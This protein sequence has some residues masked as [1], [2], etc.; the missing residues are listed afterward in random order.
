MSA[1]LSLAKVHVRPLLV[2]AAKWLAV[3]YPYVFVLAGT[4]FVFGTW[5]EVDYS[6]TEGV[7]TRNVYALVVY[8]L[9]LRWTPCSALGAC[10]GRSEEA[11]ARYSGMFVLLRCAEPHWVWL[12]DAPTFDSLVV[13][14][15]K[16]SV[17]I[18]LRIWQAVLAQAM[19]PFAMFCLTAGRGFCCWVFAQP[20][21]SGPLCR[22]SYAIFLLHQ[23][24]GQWYFWITRPGESTWGAHRKDNLWFSHV[25][26]DVNLP[27][28]VAVVSIVCV[29]AVA[30]Y[31]YF[32][33]RLY[34]LLEYFQDL[35]NH[36]NTRFIDTQTTESV[37]ARV[38]E[39]IQHACV[40]DEVMDSD[41]IVS[42]VMNSM[43]L[44]LVLAKLRR[45][46]SLS[47]S[48]LTAA[49][50]MKCNTRGD[51]TALVQSLVS[52]AVQ[53]RSG[54]FVQEAQNAQPHKV[55]KV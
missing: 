45:V 36:R 46:F 32:L 52:A 17:T 11:A 34:R 23:P 29:V 19:A 24:V 41:F 15:E 22:A 9:P 35:V 31:A 28:F 16:T 49:G 33:G 10:F 14:S 7:Q 54:D 37:Q 30:V 21:F 39:V 13:I 50:T 5:D 51:L 48:Q 6:N 4:Y 25:P 20:L 12:A 40:M 18:D 38:M 55:F 53:R 27:E 44:I 43:T 47:G 3:T 26:L 42:S 8:M 2:L 1:S